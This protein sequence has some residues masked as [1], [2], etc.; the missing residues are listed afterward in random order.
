MIPLHA[1]AIN[2]FLDD[3]NLFIIAFNIVLRQPRDRYEL[4]FNRR[5]HRIEYWS[6]ASLMWRECVDRYP[7]ARG[8]EDEW[9]AIGRAN[10][11]PMVNTRDMN[12]R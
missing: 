5:Y 11:P 12:S 2:L 1:D 3:R 4:R 9:R 10:I 6:R 8:T 7:E